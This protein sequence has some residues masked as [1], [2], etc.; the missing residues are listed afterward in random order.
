MRKTGWKPK[1][2]HNSPV[3]IQVSTETAD[4]ANLT[5]IVAGADFGGQVVPE[6]ITLFVDADQNL[7][8]LI[9]DDEVTTAEEANGFLESIGA[10]PAG[11]TEP[12]GEEIA[13]TLEEG[14]EVPPL[15]PPSEALSRGSS[16]PSQLTADE[17]QFMDLIKNKPKGREI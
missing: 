17:T 12:T 9:Y 4:P 2:E 10:E 7:D 1:R 13:P 11:I 16:M 15:A 8:H 5:E 6:G 3:T 14:A